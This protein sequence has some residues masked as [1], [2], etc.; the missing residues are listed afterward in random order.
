LCNSA[1]VAAWGG[2]QRLHE[3]LAGAQQRSPNGGR[4]LLAI[5]ISG[6]RCRGRLTRVFMS[7]RDDFKASAGID[8][9]PVAEVASLL[10]SRAVTTCLT[11]VGDTVS[12]AVCADDAVTASTLSMNRFNRDPP[13]NTS[14]APPSST[15]ANRDFFDVIQC[16]AA[17]GLPQQR[18]NFFPLPQGQG[19]LR[20]TFGVARR[21]DSEVLPADCAHSRLWFAKWR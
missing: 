7:C 3:L 2:R 20:P 16:V 5:L 1:A 14:R 17:D 4:S 11:A 21:G 10:C 19:S 6:C 18:L 13:R 8:P 15:P 12:E 9:E